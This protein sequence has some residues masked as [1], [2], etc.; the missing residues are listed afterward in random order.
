MISEELKRAL[1]IRADQ[2]SK[3]VKDFTQP[4]RDY[5]QQMLDEGT[6]VVTTSNI[7]A[8]PEPVETT[9]TIDNATV[10]T[11]SN[12]IPKP[13]KSRKKKAS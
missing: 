11:D 12:I 8:I 10:I 13:K 5:V 2:L 9:G 1:Q 3:N 7:P 4:E 6:L